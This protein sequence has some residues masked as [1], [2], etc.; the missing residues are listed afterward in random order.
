[1]ISLNLCAQLCL[2]LCDPW[3]VAHQAF[4]PWDF[5][6]K[7]TGVVFHSLLQGIFPTQGLNPRFLHLL[8]W[9]AGSLP[10]VISLMTF[11]AFCRK[12]LKPCVCICTYD[13]IA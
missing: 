9:Q 10:L 3:T 4:C 1:M 6:G 5:I 7:N 2:P 11:C 12:L 13:E 8:N